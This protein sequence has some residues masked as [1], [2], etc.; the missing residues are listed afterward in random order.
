MKHLSTLPTTAEQARRALLL[1]GAPAGAR[2]VVDVHAALFDGD[3]TPASLTRARVPGLCAALGPDLVALPG[4]VALAQWPIEQ[5]LVTPG[6][7]RADEL[8]MIIRV[9]EFAAMRRSGRAAAQLV[10]SLAERVPDGV[11]AVDLADAARA[12]LAAPAL[13]ELLAAE[14]VIREDA[15]ARASRLADR[16]QL[17]GVADLPHQRGAG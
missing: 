10:R 13:A 8:A 1:L 9:A 4:L 2:L 7:R 3:L 6:R 16:Q 12:A 15:V 5:R 14:S 11:E 17:F